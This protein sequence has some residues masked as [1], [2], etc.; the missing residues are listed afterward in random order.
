VRAAATAEAAV[1]FLGLESPGRVKAATA[2][3]SAFPQH[4]SRYRPAVFTGVD[5]RPFGFVDGRVT[6]EQLRQGFDG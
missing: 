6:R 5:L 1:V 2:P 4:N 3:I